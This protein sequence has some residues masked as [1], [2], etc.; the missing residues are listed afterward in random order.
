MVDLQQLLAA[1]IAN[2]IR[3]DGRAHS[4]YLHVMDR[5]FLSQ[6]LEASD[7]TS[8]HVG[9]LNTVSHV[10]NAQPFAPVTRS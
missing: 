3:A 1:E 2:D 8:G 6:Y 7:A 5:A 9:E 10:P 4:R